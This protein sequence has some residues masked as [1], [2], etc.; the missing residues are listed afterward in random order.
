MS[1]TTE[2]IDMDK[3]YLFR[4]KDIPGNDSEKFLKFLEDDMKILWAKTAEIKKSDD[5]KIIF[6]IDKLDNKN[7]IEFKFNEKKGR[8]I[9][10]ISGEKTRKYL[11]KEEEGK[12]KIYKFGKDIKGYIDDLEKIIA[13]DNKGKE[14]KKADETEETKEC[15][16]LFSWD[17]V[18]E[19]D[20]GQLLK[21]LKDNLKIEWTENAEIKKSR[22]ME[23]INVTNKNKNSDSITLKLNKT[24]KKVVLEI[25]GGKTYEYILKEENGKLNIYEGKIQ[26]NIVENI[27]DINPEIF[28]KYVTTM[29]IPIPKKTIDQVIG[30]C[31]AVDIIKNAAIQRRHIMLIGDPGTGKS[32]LAKAMAELLPVEELV[33]I[34]SFRNFEDENNPK[35]KVVKAGEG[36]KNVKK[37]AENTRT[38]SSGES[39]TFLYIIVFFIIPLAI[40]FYAMTHYIQID[41]TIIFAPMLVGMFLLL[42]QGMNFRQMMGV[43]TRGNVPKVIVDNANKKHAPF[44][45]ATGSHAGALFGDVKHDPLQSGGLGTPSHLRVVAGMIHKANKGLLYIDEISTLGKSQADLLTAMQEKQLSITGRSEMSSG[46]MVM[47]DP[48]PCDFIL[49]AAGNLVDMEHVHPALR[50]RIRG[51][52]YEIYL[53]NTMQDTIDNRR[54]LVRFVAQEVIKD[55][56]IPHFTKESVDVIIREAERRA[57][58]KGK[59][60]LIFRELGGLIRASGDLA[61]KR[62]HKFVE[63]NDVFDAKKIARTLEGQIGDIYMDKRKEYEVIL[64]KGISVG[65]ANGLAVFGDVGMVLPIVAEVS[66]SSSERTGQIIATGKL[67]EIA[68]EAITNVSAIIKIFMG[69]EISN[70]DIHV[71]FLQT[72]EG[73]EGDSASI[74]V[75][76]AMISAL[77]HVGIYQEVAITGSLTVRGEVLPVGGITQKIEAAIN[78][79]LKGVIIP[80]SNEKDVLLEKRYEGKIKIIPVTTI[81]DVIKYAFKDNKKIMEKINKAAN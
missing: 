12:T 76:I 4:W 47:S 70:Y 60:T 63:V 43:P 13:S 20:N 42:F 9:I 6:V 3:K 8:S 7:S 2:V 26:A 40:Y 81:V 46:A 48:V 56:K 33:D 74:A 19:K 29:E 75:T 67:G 50:S 45:D 51:Y 32:M 36:K 57:G 16:Y 37:F 30:Q 1:E 54:K 64:T 79:G 24:E 39:K 73:V 15:K 28:E 59:L 17:D 21:F 68:K 55:G 31:K 10:E 38:S 49:V 80:K 52:G 62:K 58:M 25:S 44:F 61:I 78:A 35:I 77:E 53:D 34:L 71:Q 18:P 66:P 22:N 5:G 23:T 27:E 69:K 72:Y 41:S 14:G 65:R 11:L